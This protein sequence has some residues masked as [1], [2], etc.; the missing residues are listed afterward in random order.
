MPINTSSVFGCERVS[1]PVAVPSFQ[2]VPQRRTMQE[3]SRLGDGASSSSDRSTGRVYVC[4]MWYVVSCMYCGAVRTVYEVACGCTSYV[5]VCSHGPFTGV[6]THA[7]IANT[8]HGLRPGPLGARL[9]EAVSK[10]RLCSRRTA[11][12]RGHSKTTISRQLAE[13]L[14]ERGEGVCGKRRGEGCRW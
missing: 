2:T 5:G 4:D 12:L 7:L 8:S 14:R 13:M 6:G 3:C 11:C 9:L 10:R 1:S